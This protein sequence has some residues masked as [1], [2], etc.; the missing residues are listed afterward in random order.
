VDASGLSPEIVLSRGDFVWFA[1]ADAAESQPEFPFEGFGIT[2][3]LKSPTARVP[4]AYDG[5]GELLPLGELLARAAASPGQAAPGEVLAFAASPMDVP[6]PRDAYYHHELGFVIAD[7]ERGLVFIEPHPLQGAVV[8]KVASRPGS[9][10]R[11]I[12]LAGKM[13]CATW[14]GASNELTTYTDFTTPK[15]EPDAVVQLPRAPL[16]FQGSD[17]DDDASIAYIGTEDGHLLAVSLDSAEVLSDTALSSEPV[18]QVALDGRRLYAACGEGGLVAVDVGDADAP[19][20]PEVL[21]D[22]GPVDAVCTVSLDAEAETLIAGPDTGWRRLTGGASETPA[23]EAVPGAEALH[24]RVAEISGPSTGTVMSGGASTDHLTI[25]GAG[26]DGIHVYLG[27]TAGALH[28]SHQIA[29]P[30]LAMAWGSQFLASVGPDALWFVS[31]SEVLPEGH[32]R[33]QFSVHAGAIAGF[34]GGGISFQD[35][36]CH[37][38]IAMDPAGSLRELG[39]WGTGG[40]TPNMLTLADRSGQVMV[41]GDFKLM[42][43]DLGLLSAGTIATIGKGGLTI[44]GEHYEAGVVLELA[45]EGTAQPIGRLRH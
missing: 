43:S 17:K 38:Y 24:V 21:A 30:C 6:A 10:A 19:G 39:E 3:P 37:G 1:D 22:L 9:S 45:A 34:A 27:A 36:D 8:A 26:A 28:A 13:I 42:G 16:S 2:T 5:L 33:S 20:A 40:G 44:G 32:E 7:A 14:A 11:T 35:A 18:L 12:G 4:Y 29:I 15:P 23:A 41:I 31:L 25:A